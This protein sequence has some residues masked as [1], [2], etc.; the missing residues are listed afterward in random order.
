MVFD[1]YNIVYLISNI[2]GTY[3]IY[4]FMKVFFSESQT[5]KK[6]EWISYILYFFV[7]SVIYLMFK[8][9]VLNLVT[10]IIAF[11]LLTLNYVA[12]W[13]LRLAATLLIYAIMITV[14]AIVVL[15]VNYQNSD[16]MNIED[17]VE[18][19]IILISVKI[20]SYVVILALSNFKMVR[21][22]VNHS[23]VH[24][25]AIFI[26]PIGTL[27]TTV[28]LMTLNVAYDA[29]LILIGVTILFIVNIFVFYLYDVLNKLYKEKLEKELLLQQNDAYS[30]Q[31]E[32]I[33]DSQENIRRIKHDIK[34][35]VSVV[36]NLIERK[37]NAAALEYN[38]K[39]IDTMEFP[40]NYISSGNPE[41]DSILNYKINTAQKAGIEV[42]LDV[43]IPEKISVT[44][45]DFSVI[46][47]NLLDNAIEATSKVDK[48]RKIS[49]YIRFERGII[50]IQIVNPYVGKLNYVGDKLKT[51]HKNQSDRGL[52]LTSVNKSIDNYNGM[53]EF[54]TTNNQFSVEVLIYV[55]DDE[56]A[57]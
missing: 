47:G 3:V 34:N 13:K 9:P 42:E 55:S 16:I 33:R 32:L 53:I 41:L 43:S 8:S 24:W 35:H 46:L 15:G 4:R 25:L 23:P 30:K 20:L 22:N 40:G 21:N 11:V 45:F 50:Y 51:T 49:G 12:T 36:D 17:G 18:L 44:P 19:I 28:L 39:I 7:L 14:E 2:F 52:G 26:V 27:F 37:E 5:S 54:H 31:F 6:V 56:M 10:N 48:D 29:S 38:R 57:G 1:T